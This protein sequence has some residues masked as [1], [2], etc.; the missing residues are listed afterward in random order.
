M[1]EYGVTPNGVVIKRLDTIMEELHSDLSEGWG[2]NTRLNPKSYLNVQLTAFAD[3]IAE[4]WEFGGEIY[5]SMYPS[6]AEDISLDNAAQFGG[7]TREQAAKTYYPIHCQGV[8]GTVITADTMIRS[9]TNPS[10]NFIATDP[11]PISRSSFNKAQVKVLAVAPEN[12]Y[13][14][15]LNGLLYSYTADDGDAEADILSSLAAAITSEEFTAKVDNGLLLIEAKDIQSSNALVLTENLT[16]ESV[17]SVINFGSEDYGEVVLPNGT[18]TKIVKGVTGFQSCTNLCGY[19]AGRL[20]E[21][22]VEFRKSYIDKIFVRSSRMLDSIKSAIL[23]NVQGVES[24]AAYENDTN[25]TD[26]E[27]RPPHSIEI[28]VDGGG[29]SE[30]AEQILDQ[31]AGGIITYGSVEVAVPGEEG[32]DIMIRFNRPTYVY[33]WFKV[34][35][36]MSQTESLPPNYAD[37]IKESIVSQMEEVEAGSKVVTQKF[38]AQ[39]YDT[40]S[41]IDYIDITAFSTSDASE[42]PDEYTERIVT[43][44][45]RERAVTDE[46]RIE[47]TLDG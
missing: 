13:T 7:S 46:T 30:I 36:T 4:L 10:I 38:L 33:I 12:V 25:E 20:R 18:I 35:V 39:I 23:Q 26:D 16:T 8:D 29:N 19:I 28:V 40:V 14:V 1:P 37:L 43:I 17:T 22:D 27:G 3:K 32:E 6:S 15:A 21:T 42:S 11:A 5:Y 45:A 9:D 44:S 31:K 24:V 41:G 47:V 34:D 2:V